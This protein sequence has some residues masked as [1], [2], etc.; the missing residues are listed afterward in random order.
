MGRLAYGLLP[1]FWCMIA[2]SCSR[3]AAP[4]FIIA[5]WIWPSTV[6]TERTFPD[7]TVELVEVNSPA[8]EEALDRGEIDLG[9]L[10]PALARKQLRFRALHDETFVLALPDGHRLADQD[11]I[12]FADLVGEPLLTAP[13]SVG[14]VLFDKLIG[15][16]RAAGVEPN[17]VQEATPVTTLAGPVAAGAGIGFVTRGVAIASRPGVVFC[18]VIGALGVPITVAWVPPEPTPTGQQFIDVMEAVWH[19]DQ[20]LRCR[21]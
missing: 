5:R 3:L 14:P 1:G 19:T 16:F 10:Q 11:T 15:R 6:R 9:V 17:V 12:T 4:V 13:R 21:G 2:A 7:M 20:T 8:V 18:E